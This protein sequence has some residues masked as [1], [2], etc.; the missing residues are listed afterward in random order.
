MQWTVEKVISDLFTAWYGREPD[1]ISPLPPSGS[2]RQYYR[3]RVRDNSVVA[4]FNPDVRENLAFLKLS[5]HFYDL[6][7]P[8]PQVLAEDTNTHCYLLTDLGDTTLFSLLP[9]K[10]EAV[11]FDEKVMLLYKKTISHLPT[12]QVDAAKNLDFSICY[13]RHA[14]DR[15]SMMWD[16]NYFKYYFLK[17]SGIQFDEQLL[18]EDFERFTEHLMLTPADYFMYRDFQSRNVMIQQGSPYYI[19]YQGGRK[20]PLAYDIASLLYDAKANIPVE[21]REELLDYYLD[22]LEKKIDVDR[23]AFRRSFYDFVLMRIMQALGSYGFRGGV[24]KKPLF[25]QSVPFALKNL[26]WLASKDLL[27][28][29]IPHLSGL[30]R[31]IATIAPAEILPPP[32]EGLTVKVCSF[33]Y[34]KGIPSDNS[35]NGGGFVFDCRALPN[36]GRKTEFK[37]LTGKDPEVIN[38]LE[39]ESSIRAFIDAAAALV[40]PAVE[41][42]LERNFNS[43]LVCFG[44]TG[45]QHRSV[46]CA[47]RLSKLLKE[48]YNAN[49]ELQHLEENSWPQNIKKQRLPK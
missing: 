17:I 26:E 37:E 22:Q 28:E 43:L 33:S 10:R 42:Y 47:E 44:C 21:Q 40:K 7:L 27:P 20:G 32:P 11:M 19:D 23:E 39:S 13:P 6:G 4:A 36:P 46:Y 5:A 15:H 48:Q 35:G 9:Q 41:N 45:G 29:N 25:L 24:E 16:L 12:F 18:E 2:N 31:K 8:V 38:Y 49:V 34:R 1:S 14:F 30:I 3:I